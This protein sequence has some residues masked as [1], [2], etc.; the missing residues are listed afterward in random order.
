[1]RVAPLLF[2]AL[3][4]LTMAASGPVTSSVP[5]GNSLLAAARK[6]AKAAADRLAK[7][8]AEAAKA[9]NEAARLRGQQAVATAAIDEAEARIS[10]AEAEYRV[11]NATLMLAEAR[12]AER[13]APVAALLAGL[14]TMGRQPPLLVLA[15]GGGPEELVRVKAL[16]DATRP[17]IAART[18]A[19]KA[20]VARRQTL[21]DTAAAARRS[22]ADGRKLLE[23]RRSEFAELELEAL[24][25]QQ[26]LVGQT[27]QAGD[28]VMASD[29]QLAEA[30][31]A[32]AMRRNAL[33][34]AAELVPAGLAP[35]R[36]F[37]PDQ[38]KA[39]APL[40]YRL[41][42]DAPLLDGL[43]SISQSGI[44]SRGVKFD[45]PRG[46]EVRAP[47]GGK[48]L[49]AAPYR[50][51]D[52]VIII[53]HGSGRSTMLLGLSPDLK[54]GER[55]AAGEVLGKALGPLSVE[56]RDNGVLKS[57]AF[58][59]ASSVALSNTGKAR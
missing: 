48:I 47:A 36:P 15:D 45:T 24:G 2:S 23:R 53:D 38:G 41:P 56:F 50:G 6:D 11:A 34:M 7:L 10:Q 42:V 20:D 1:M 25:R 37:A 40:P 35:P 57:P 21:A 32:A 13:R 9:G 26:A 52:G 30:D 17:V 58:I 14:V 12:L 44:V 46:I 8:E 29:E 16:L 55:V 19:L 51:Y 3:A 18:A 4:A 49:F 28:V 33:A 31:S 59:A 22:L 5:S 39:V 54:A 43:G 27:V